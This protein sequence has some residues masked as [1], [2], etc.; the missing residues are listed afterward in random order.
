MRTPNWL[1]S[2]RGEEHFYAKLGEVAKKIKTIAS[3]YQVRGR[4]D[5]ARNVAHEPEYKFGQGQHRPVV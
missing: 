5:V 1:A 2:A 4:L 3:V